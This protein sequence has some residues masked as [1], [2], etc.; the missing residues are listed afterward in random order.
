MGVTVHYMTAL[1]DAGEILEQRSMTFRA[2]ASIFEATALLFREGADLLVAQ[3][4]RLERREGGTP[5]DA[6]G[7]YQSWPGRSEIRALHAR[8]GA[9]M[10]LSDFSRVLRAI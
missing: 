4:G 8:G 9:L 7:C 6:P 3:I 1:L 2:R 10:R 5:Q